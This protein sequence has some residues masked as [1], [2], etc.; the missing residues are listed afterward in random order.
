[1]VFF[2]KPAWVSF[3]LALRGKMCHVEHFGAS[4][5]ERSRCFNGN[6]SVAFMAL[7]EHSQIIVHS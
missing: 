6:L 4:R 5:A 2:L 7:D 1:M 3:L